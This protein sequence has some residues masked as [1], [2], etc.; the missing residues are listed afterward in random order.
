MT[1][2]IRGM[3]DK[4]RR[5]A[6]ENSKT[7][8]AQDFKIENASITSTGWKGVHPRVP[9]RKRLTNMLLCSS[10]KLME[11]LGAFTRVCYDRQ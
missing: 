10:P 3:E 2:M 4:R 5:Y 6:P 11:V 9:D 8:Q 7:I 1:K